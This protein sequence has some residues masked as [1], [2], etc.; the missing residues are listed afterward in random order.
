M[1]EAEEMVGL[2]IVEEAVEGLSQDK[3]LVAVQQGN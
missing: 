1:P 2:L 3:N